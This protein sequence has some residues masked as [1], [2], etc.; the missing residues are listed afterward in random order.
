M[1]G[2]VSPKTP[3]ILL[4]ALV[5]GLGIPFGILFLL[6]FFRYKIDG[7]E[8]VEKLTKLPILGMSP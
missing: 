6:E 3:I 4:A 5:L 7:H 1:E 8:D 2:K